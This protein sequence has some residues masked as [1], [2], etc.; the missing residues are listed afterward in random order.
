[1]IGSTGLGPAPAAE[2][3]HPLNGSSSLRVSGAP[4]HCALVADTLD[5][6]GTEEVV[7]LLA[8]R[9]PAIG[10]RT[11]VFYTSGIG[12]TV[13]HAPRTAAAL[14]AEGIAV[15]QLTHATAKARLAEWRPD[16][17]SAHAPATWWVELAA[18]LGIP[19]LETLH[20]AHAFFDAP[21]MTKDMR[22]RNVAS[23]SARS[24]N[25]ASLIAVSELV[26]QQYLA[27][28]PDVEPERVVTVPNSV[29]SARIPALDPR[30]CR[31]WLGLED[32]FLFVTLARHSL[33]K[34]TYGL[35]S[36]FDE[37][38]AAYPEAHLLIAGRPDEGGYP[39]QAREL[40]DA[41]RSR[42]R[43]HLRDHAPWPAAVLGAA[44]AF[45]LDS[46][47]EGW[48]LA[49]MEALY[50]GLPVVLSDVGGARE[51]VGDGGDRG[52]LVGNPVGDRLAVNWKTIDESLYAR[53]ANRDE[54]VAA[55]C[56]TVER[57]H[58][59]ASRRDE[60]RRESAARFHPDHSIRGH[61][62]VIRRAVENA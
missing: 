7:A 17:I 5:V 30:A 53:Q 40:R 58:H 41:L 57:R 46:Y 11:T 24:R 2:T 8:R 12:G 50:A 36:A 60:L 21:W 25:V 34:N 29:E 33:Q 16:V 1:M 51:Q 35:I 52:R 22:S 56:A 6:G 26:R 32:E 44:N 20:G 4:L 42:D 59:W 45:V 14:A 37:V 10:I 47:F 28:H 48:S 61:A 55:M 18:E 43:I 62:A 3:A 27:T 23:E 15:V 9:L 31:H 49:S 13:R 39:H 54:L 38:A 19:Y